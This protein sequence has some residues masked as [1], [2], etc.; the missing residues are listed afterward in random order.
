MAKKPKTGRRGGGAH[1]GTK[2]AKSAGGTR[3]RSG[4]GATAKGRTSKTSAGRGRSASKG[5]G[6]AAS[7][8][9]ARPKSQARASKAMKGRSAATSRSTTKSRSSGAGAPEMKRRGATKARG[10]SSGEARAKVG[11][12]PSAEQVGGALDFGIPADRA[13]GPVEPGGFGKGP[14][15]GTGPMRSGEEGVRTSGVGVPPGPPGTGSGGDLDPD[16]IGFDDGGAIANHP[17]ERRTQGP[18]IVESDTASRAR[19]SARR[20]GAPSADNRPR[21]PIVAGSKPYLDTVDH[22]GGDVSTSGVAPDDDFGI[23]T[24]DS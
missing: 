15:P 8:G 18:D 19:Q 5:K 6:A 2:S 4:A 23:D 14:E 21:G 7:R 1:P 13:R 22:S 17:E 20:S 9:A 3:A 11:S 16:F 12:N 10:R 24:D